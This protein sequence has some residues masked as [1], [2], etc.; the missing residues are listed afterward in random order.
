MWGPEPARTSPRTAKWSRSSL[1]RSCLPKTPVPV[2]SEERPRVCPS[3]TS[4]SM[5]RWQFLTVHHWRDLL[6][7][8]REV[9]RVARRQVISTWDP[10]HDRR[11]WIA[12]EYI[13]A[14]IAMEAAR[15][16]TLP[17]I[18][19][20]LDAHTVHRFE[21][22]HDFTDGFQAALWRN[23]EAYL[24]P[25]IRA[26]SS[27][28]AS[29]PS[30]LVEPGIAQLRRDLGSGVWASEHSDLLGLGRELE[31]RSSA[32]VGSHLGMRMFVAV[33]P[34]EATR[35][36]LASLGLGS[37]PGL[38]PVRPRQWH[39][40]LRFLGVVDEGLV[41]ALVD[42]LGDAADAITG[43]VHCEVGPETAWFSRERVLQIPVAGLDEAAEAVRAATIPVVPSS[44]A[45]EPSFTGHLTIAR[46]KRR[47][48]DA[49][50]RAALV[51]IP[52][53]ASFDVEAFA[54]VASELSSDGPRY[55]TLARIP[56]RG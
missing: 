40:T 43:S 41:P 33:W 27:T 4:V 10:D 15:F 7:G 49:S 52:F 17:R 30:E 54:L 32:C 1:L 22:P 24:D 18:V 13:P 2:G 25:R 26:A 53:A 36:R 11:L 5:R 38:R 48:P 47:R 12:T 42:A 56:L 28:F 51:G 16:A 9:K 50:A 37:V 23:P 34:D 3:P 8:L 29:L 31:R 45:D 44:N 39:M 21:I 46:S 35:Q 19:G 14:I 55:A 20:A 6:R